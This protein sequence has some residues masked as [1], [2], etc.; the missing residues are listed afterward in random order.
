MYH[1]AKKNSIII[2]KKSHRKKRGKADKIRRSALNFCKKWVPVNPCDGPFIAITVW[3]IKAEKG[4]GFFLA[5]VIF[6]RDMVPL[7][8]FYCVPGR[9]IF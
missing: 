7:F 6:N 8:Y 3:Y 4:V 2:T 1:I 5:C 9:G